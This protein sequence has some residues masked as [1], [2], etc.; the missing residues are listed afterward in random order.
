M[1]KISILLTA[2]LFAANVF[3]QDTKEAAARAQKAMEETD[4][5]KL[6]DGWKK[7]ADV[8]FGTVWTNTDNWVGAADKYNITGT[9]N[10]VLKA[11]R[12][13]GRALWLNELRWVYGGIASPSTKDKFRK[14]QDQL[15]LSS[16]YAPQIKPKWF[17][18]VKLNLNTQLTN[19]RL[20]DANGNAVPG[21]AGLASGFMAPGVI[22]LGV[23]VLYRPNPNFK[24]YFSPLTANIT[25]KF[26]KAYKPR[27]GEAGFGVDAN[28]TIQFGLGAALT[29][30]YQTTIIKNINYK[31]RLDL[32]TDYLREP[33]IKTDMD[34]LNS[35]NFNLTKNISV[36]A[37]FNLR[38]YPFISNKTQYMHTVGLSG[39]FKL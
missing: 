4:I 1:K 39:G 11:D 28:K 29:A 9:L 27:T 13:Q 14:A 31:T 26:G 35:F 22:R 10:T 20:Y 12:K 33:F 23:G 6:P 16:M 5:T 17:W 15:L 36:G 8:L 32:F 37:V 19:T 34:W 18:G 3:A 21:D 38:H 24:L 30:E 2:T 25:T 7:S